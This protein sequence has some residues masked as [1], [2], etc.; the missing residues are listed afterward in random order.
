MPAP[1]QPVV[2]SSGIAE[3]F[4]LDAMAKELMDDAVFERSGRV[5][6]TL[7][8]GDDMT[9][10]LTVMQKGRELHEHSA[11][12]PVT[13]TVLS[14]RLVFSF[15]ASRDD[16]VLS[17]GSALVFSKDF[18]HTVKA[19]EDSAFLMVIGGKTEG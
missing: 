19:E 12:G 5:A 14:G 17:R 15:D 18:A 11:P 9:A 16:D 2:L 1:Y 6:R 8:R 10:V 7:A 3:S 4:D 13:V